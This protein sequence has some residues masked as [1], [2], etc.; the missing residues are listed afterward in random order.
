M[1]DF[2][3]MNLPG[4]QCATVGSKAAKMLN[5]VQGMQT[6]KM[7]N[8]LMLSRFHYENL[9]ESCNERA[10][11]ITLC[12]YGYALFQEDPDLGLIHTPCHLSGPFNIYYES[13]N[14]EAFSYNYN[15]RVTIDESV[16][17]RCNNTMT[18]DYLIL[19]NFV[20]KI[21]NAI[22]SVDVHTNTIKRP[23]LIAGNEKEIK[24]IKRVLEDVESNEPAIAGC[25]YTDGSTNGI[26]VMSLVQNSFLSEMWGNVKNYYQ[27]VYTAL[28]I[29]NTYS[30]KKERLV[31]SESIGEESPIRHIMESNLACRERAIEEINKKWG[32]NI[33][34]TC[35]EL[36]RFVMEDAEKYM[37]RM[38]TVQNPMASFTTE[39]TDGGEE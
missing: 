19:M 20:P 29:Y 14:R 27:Q 7:F 30:Q 4:F 8:D 10:L 33:V 39:N 38:A 17:M 35:N 24:S 32:T 18:P 37:A 2:M 34:V 25:K 6:Y 1:F 9:P 11:E 21:I 15:R 31:V 3:G 5:S 16:L 12:Y 36:D 23:F 13:I 26:Q 22:R 28:G